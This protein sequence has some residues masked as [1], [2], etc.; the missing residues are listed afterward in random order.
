MAISTVT[1]SIE[2]VGNGSTS[3]PY[4]IPFPFLASSHIHV[5]VTETESLGYP[6]NIV[7]AGPGSTNYHVTL[8]E[9]TEPQDDEVPSVGDVLI[10]E[11]GNEGTILSVI[12]NNNDTCVLRVS[13]ADPFAPGLGSP[14]D[15][16]RTETLEAS[17]YIVTRLEDGSGGSLV[18]T[19]VVSPSKKI[20]ILRDVP[21][22]QPTEFQPAG[23]FPAESTETALDRL[24]MQI[25]QLHRRMQLLEKATD[26]S[27]VEIPVGGLAIY[28]TQSWTN[29]VARAT[30]APD[31]VGQLGLQTGDGM[32][33]RGFGTSAGAWADIKYRAWDRYVPVAPGSV[34]G[35]INM[36]FFG[37][38]PESCTLRE[39]V[40]CVNLPGSIEMDL[41]I[42]S[43]GGATINATMPVGAF[44][45]SIPSTVFLTAG[46]R[47][48]LTTAGDYGSPNA[49]GLEIYLVSDRS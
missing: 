45:V 14:L 41:T 42:T 25:Q 28:G 4:T 13:N 31:F 21:L 23:P 2:L 40:F 8:N 7:P 32:V 49:T 26:G 29:S 48:F 27:H 6:E 9:S 47:L 18:T 37:T 22:T 33:F 35:T 1:S 43:M 11:N 16:R 36:V 24:T 20:T 30:V 39:V 10:D 12:D 19:A 46:D 5:A 17:D 38:V 34:V 3:T 44:S 15:V